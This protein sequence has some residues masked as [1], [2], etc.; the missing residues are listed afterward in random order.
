MGDLPDLGFGAIGAEQ[1]KGV[2][3]TVLA[4]RF[5]TLRTIDEIVAELRR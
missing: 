5:A 2:I 3:A 1:A 4:H